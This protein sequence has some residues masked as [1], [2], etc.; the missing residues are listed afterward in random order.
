MK[1]YPGIFIALVV[2]LAVAVAV[3]GAPPAQGGTVHIVQWGESL[4][5][6]AARY[7][8]T[9]EAIASANGLTNPNLIYAGQRLII[10]A[11]PVAPGP[12]G[13]YIVKRGDTLYSIA[14]RYGTTVNALINANNLPSAMI[15]IGQRLIIPG[16]KPGPAP[17]SHPGMTR[18][19]VQPGDTLE[20]IARRYGVTVNDIME[21][22]NL[23]S[24]W[25][26]YPNQTLLIP[27]GQKPAPNQPTSSYYIVQPGD[28]LS[29]IA[30]RHGTTVYAL[31]RANNLANPSY[32]YPGQQLVIP[33]MAA[34]PQAPLAGAPPSVAPIVPQIAPPGTPQPVPTKVSAWPPLPALPPP[35]PAAP[36]D[37]RKE[38]PEVTSVWKGRLVA[39][40]N[41]SHDP[42]VFFLSILRVSANG[43]KGQAVKVTEPLTGWYT[44]AI[45]GTKPEYG[46]YACEFAPLNEGTYNVSLPGIGA[47]INVDIEPGTATYVEFNKVPAD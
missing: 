44:V 18:Y 21:I 26:I 17:E 15:Y 31:V 8:T 30:L 11:G 1:I 20:A 22:N 3:E 38:A 43:L 37:W 12:G 4:G 35:A 23:Y 6:I 10:P 7:G 9:V 33:G 45:A 16:G 42:H 19:I 39:V 29:S 25:Y 36:P 40:E 34:A 2:T 28:T 14:R 41:L 5:A 13:T 24:P 32:I 46:E 47:S 27:A